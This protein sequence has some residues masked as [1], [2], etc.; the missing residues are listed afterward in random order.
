MS[1]PKKHRFLRL[2]RMEQVSAAQ[3]KRENLTDSSPL[4]LL[5]LLS[6]SEFLQLKEEI[7]TNYAG[8]L[9]SSHG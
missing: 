1:A 7:T 2:M 9:P 8:S 6:F 5:A 3:I 4:E